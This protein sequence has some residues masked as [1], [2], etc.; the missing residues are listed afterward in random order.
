MSRRG[1]G[2]GV[3]PGGSEELLGAELRARRAL[4]EYLWRIELERVMTRSD[5]PFGRG[6]PEAENLQAGRGLVGGGKDPL[7]PER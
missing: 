1:G 3:V 7:G 4:G 5:L 2:W 6:T